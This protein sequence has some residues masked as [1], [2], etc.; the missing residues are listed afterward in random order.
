MSGS[1]DPR[2]DLP[3]LDRL[4]STRNAGE[5]ILRWGRPAVTDA[6]R[7][8]VDEFRD[9]LNVGT[10]ETL[11]ARESD[12]LSAAD[13]YLARLDRPGLRAVLNGTGVV[14]HTNLG[15]APLSRAALD[16]VM[17]V[18]RGYCNLEF[19]LERG[20]RGDRYEHC[21][22]WIRKLTGSEDALVVN[23]TAA[24][25]ALTVNRLAERKQVI[26]SRGELVEI[27]G[28]FRLPEV[29]RASGGILVE[30]G[31]TNRT[32]P[33]DYRAAIGPQTALLLKVHP[34]N[35]RIEG[36][37]EQTELSELV[38]IGREASIPVAHDLGSGLLMPGLVPLLPAEPTPAESVSAGADLVMWSGDKLLGGSQAGIIHG[39][40]E[41][42]SRLRQSPMLRAFRVDKLTLAALETTLALYAYPD[43]AAVEIPVLARLAESAE[44]VGAR[45]RRLRQRLAPA[46]R[47]RVR[48]V[49]LVSLVGGGTYPGA[50]L[51][52]AG[53]RIDASARRVEESCRAA[54]SP[55]IGRIEGDSFILDFRTLSPDEDDEA[56]AALIG[57]ILAAESG[58]GGSAPAESD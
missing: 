50:E 58:S 18:G 13:R 28:S 44:S 23:N 4:L 39:R 1:D 29:V 14:L 5:S 54:E 56:A 24:A 25:I 36:F 52:S 19:D 51:P 21:S 55:L 16:S 33:A 32:R 22:A 34:S 2:R 48:V 12:I 45:A 6:L 47:D 37:T 8:V 41:W 57:R 42:I 3:S 35:Y 31:T 15:R 38:Q 9:E 49:D 46:V 53:W 43:R 26:V 7:A 20:E 30:V 27:G 11:H 10:R 17:S 40:K